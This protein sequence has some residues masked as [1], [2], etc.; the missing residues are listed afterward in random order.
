[1]EWCGAPGRGGA[2]QCM[3]WCGVKRKVVCDGDVGG[4]KGVAGRRNHGATIRNRGVA[5]TESTRNATRNVRFPPR[6]SRRSWTILQQKTHLSNTD[7]SQLP[8]TDLIAS[9]LLASSLARRREERQVAD[10]WLVVVSKQV[11]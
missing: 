11:S 6:P 2:W 5:R 10:R 8:E 3:V 7:G 4:Y 1:M 9:H